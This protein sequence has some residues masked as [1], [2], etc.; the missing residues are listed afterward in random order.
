VPDSKTKKDRFIV[1]RIT[2][3]EEKIIDDVREKYKISI[4]QIFEIICHCG[5]QEGIITANIKQ[6]KNRVGGVKEVKIPRNILSK[7]KT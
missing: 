4:R 7:K 5:C 2:P 3:Y 1:M 6:D